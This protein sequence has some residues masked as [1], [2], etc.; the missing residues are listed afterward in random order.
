MF[1]ALKRGFRSMASLILVRNVVGELRL[2]RTLAA[3][4][5]FLAA[6]RL[7]CLVV[8]MLSV[9]CCSRRLACSGRVS[10]S[11]K[12][13]LPLMGEVDGPSPNLTPRLVTA[14][15][16]CLP[17]SGGKLR[18]KKNIVSS[19]ADVNVTLYA[20]NDIVMTVSFM[21]LSW[22]CHWP[23]SVTSV[24]KVTAEL[25]ASLTLSVTTHF[26]RSLGVLLDWTCR[27]CSW[28]HWHFG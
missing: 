12:Q 22:D 15:T 1:G 25:T 4:R 17:R 26:Y 18:S 8:W 20:I 3:S 10:W 16:D 14:I 9:S 24:T 19:N 21:T 28:K 27:P 5:G 2:K 6:A 7:S 11:S 13:V 23:R